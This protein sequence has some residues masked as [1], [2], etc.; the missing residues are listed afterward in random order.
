MADSCQTAR[1]ASIQSYQKAEVSAIHGLNQMAK[2]IQKG[3][4]GLLA[5]WIIDS[6]MPAK[7]ASTTGSDGSLGRHMDTVMR[8]YTAAHKDL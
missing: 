6:P 7:K 1:A 2:T 3:L 5:S 4:E 8:Y